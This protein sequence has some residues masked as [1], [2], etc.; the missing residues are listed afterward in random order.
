MYCPGRGLRW[1]VRVRKHGAGLSNL[2]FAAPGTQILEITPLLA[3]AFAYWGMAG[4]L[5]LPY[6]QFAATDAHLMTGPGYGYD[7]SLNDRALR[8]DVERLDDMRDPLLS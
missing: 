4:A 6:W 5:G 7:G 1:A 8:I 2:G 3:G